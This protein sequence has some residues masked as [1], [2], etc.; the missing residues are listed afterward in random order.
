MATYLQGVTDYIPEFQPFQP[1][2]NFYSN[3]LQTKQSQYDSNWKA[4]NKMYG[5]YFY[6]DLTREGNIKKKD[7]L[8]KNM[9]FNL[10]RVSQLDLSLEQNVNQATQVFKPF[11]E[12]KNL[13]KDMAW[14]KTYNSQVGRAQALQGSSD[15][16]RRKQFWD[17]GLKE[18]QYKKDEFKKATDAEAM[19]FNNVAYTP[20]VNSVELAQ[21]IAKDAGLSIETVDFSPD[22]KWIITQ[23]NGEKLKEPLSKLF[24]ARLGSDPQVQAVYKTQAYVNRKDYAYSNA[25]QFNGDQNAAEMKYLEDSFNILKEQNIQRYKAVQDRDKAYDDKIKLL[26]KQIADKKAGPDAQKQLDA[27]KQGKEINGKILERVEKQNN[28]LNKNSSSTPSTSTG[29][30]NPYGDINSLRWKVDA[31]MA[32]MLMSKDLNEAAEIFAYKDAKTNIK[33]NPYKVLE[34]K[35]A[36]SMQQIHTRGAYSTRA[37]TIKARGMTEA[38]RLRNSGEAENLKNAE[39]L[40]RGLVDIKAVGAVD[41][42]NNPI[43]DPNTGKQKIN[44]V[45][46]PKENEF[47]SELINEETGEINPYDVASKQNQSVVST[48]FGAN[49]QIA[50][51]M[52]IAMKSGNMSKEDAAEILNNPDVAKA[53]PFNFEGSSKVTRGAILP[54][55]INEWVYESGSLPDY[56]GVKT[57]DP[58]GRRFKAPIVTP[59][60]LGKLT[61]Q[62]I[63]NIGQA[64]RAYDKEG[65]G[66]YKP[67]ELKL[68][69]E[70]SNYYT[71]MTERLSEFIND[72]SNL[73]YIQQ[74]AKEIMDVIKPAQFAAIQNNNYED[75][76]FKFK[77]AILAENPGADKLFDANNELIHKD[78]INDIVAQSIYSN[79]AEPNDI[80]FFE[81][82]GT[83]WNSVTGNES[84]PMKMRQASNYWKSLFSSN[85][86]PPRLGWL[87]E[88]WT[89]Y[90]PYF[91]GVAGMPSSQEDLKDYMYVVMKDQLEEAHD[92]IRGNITSSEWLQQKN[93]A[94]IPGVGK[95]GEGGTGLSSTRSYIEVLPMAVG[96]KGFMAWQTFVKDFKDIGQFDGTKNAI[97]FGGNGIPG[98][99]VSATTLDGAENQTAKGFALLNSMIDAINDPNSDYKPFTLKAQGIAQGSMDRGAMVVM[100]NADW[101][102][103]FKSTN[104]K[105]D[106]NLLTTDEYNA[107]LQNGI[108]VVSDLSNFNNTAMNTINKTPL[109]SIVDYNGSYEEKIPGAG[110]FKIEKN[111]TLK[112]VSP[113]V[114]S[115]EYQLWDPNKGAFSTNI[116]Y[117]SFLPKDRMLEN[118]R[119][120]QINLLYGIQDV[121]NKIYNGIYDLNF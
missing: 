50:K 65:L 41:K 105:Q 18:L 108:S 29:F 76:K 5:Q 81:S 91:R 8:L 111:S 1:D 6:A 19:S 59:E 27:L 26:E 42:D 97:L 13:M 44:Y 99:S 78:A 49:G 15:E 80:G 82:I 22:G 10:K 119:Q 53:S 62:D 89:K 69:Q 54:K 47:K 75:W 100:P 51:W 25:A 116:V 11:Y 68:T 71:G 106:N 110:T 24:E 83:I 112:G 23:K 38:A 60:N 88:T 36:Q 9:E 35:H 118:Q 101:L 96:T 3:V 94:D 90:S 12:D 79:D 113:Y 32:S 92:K 21:K 4:L 40:K 72:N 95:L 43:I 55:T 30:V 93:L 37:A 58:E 121:N 45:T 33:E 46:V 57:A 39:L 109:E 70:T 56:K 102:K 98:T 104:D 34:V 31:G 61:A 7:E 66:F 20:Y 67:S 52:E 103:Q 120:E 115:T 64:Q 85:N 107:I 63:Y 86:A 87:G 73:P 48:I 14:T 28:E 84:D 17:A 74:T 2:L 16:E 117:E 114:T 77:E